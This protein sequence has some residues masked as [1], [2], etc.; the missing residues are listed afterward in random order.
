M[1]LYKSVF[2]D[3]L[4]LTWK[5]KYFWFLG[6]F[7]IFFSSS[8]EI[9]MFDNFFGPNRNYLSNYKAILENNMIKGGFVTGLKNWI[10]NDAGSFYRMLLFALAFLAV[11]LILLIISSIA[12][13]I[14]TG[15]SASLIKA[16]NNLKNPKRFN[17]LENLKK[18]K[19][20]ITP[21][22]IINFCLKLMVNIT[23]IIIALPM[24]ISQSNAVNWLYIILFVILFPAAI[25]IAFITRYIA[26]YIII[27]GQNFKQAFKNG[28]FLFKANWLVSAEMSLM[29]F[30]V[31]IF[32]S[33]AVIFI[34]LAIANPL[35]FL[36]IL[37]NQ[38]IYKGG[39]YVILAISY[40]IFFALFALGASLLA[41]FNISSWT[42]LFLKLDKTGGESKIVR[43][44]SGLI[45]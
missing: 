3:S 29:L 42:N 25:I 17:F 4:K 1:S 9:D 44:L 6:V 27:Y 21:V 38:Y 11:F 16:G 23:L 26:S 20:I 13:I 45:K 19:S 36:G 22:A 32:G 15:H 14:I 18:I 31:N 7:T 30:L 8:V 34:I 41:V 35:W 33:L 40:V 24:I 12:Q 37:I 5:N 10:E 28:F 2:K 39:F 43:T